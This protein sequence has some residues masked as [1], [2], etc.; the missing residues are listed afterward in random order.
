MRKALLAVGLCALLAGPA[1]AQDQDKEARAVIDKAIHAQGGIEKLKSIDKAFL[2]K[3]KGTIS[4]M[5]M[6]L[7]FTID[8]F[9]QPPDKSKAIINLSAGGQQLTIIQVFNGKKGWVSFMGQTKDAEKEEIDEHLAMIHV[10][11]V[12]NLYTLT[13]DRACKLSPLGESKVDGKEVVGVQVTKKDKRDVNLYFDKKSHLL[14][15]SEYRAMDPF[16]K[17]ECA[18]EK[19]YSEYKEL[20]PGI[21]MAAKQT[22]NNDGKLFMHFEMTE[23]RGVERHD[24]SVFARPE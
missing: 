9:S 6:D 7:D 20:L 15:K 24:D 19:L 11:A 4:A 1:A 23:V 18:Q 14:V 22:V 13:T 2:A 8:I 10:E 17:Q 12:S 5:G 16:T 3:G 21:K